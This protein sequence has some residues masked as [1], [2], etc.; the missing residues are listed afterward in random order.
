MDPLPPIPASADAA[1]LAVYETAP[2]RKLQCCVASFT[3]ILEPCPEDD[4]FILKLREWTD[5]TRGLLDSKKITDGDALEQGKRLQEILDNY[6]DGGLSILGVLEKYEK[7]CAPKQQVLSPTE[8]YLKKLQ[9]EEEMAEKA[10]LE[11]AGKITLSAAQIKD[12]LEKTK[13]SIEVRREAFKAGSLQQRQ[14]LEDHQEELLQI[15]AQITNDIRVLAQE[16]KKIAN[17]I[18]RTEEKTQELKERA[19][20]LNTNLEIIQKQADEARKNLTKKNN[21]FKEFCK[22]VLPVALAVLSVYSLG[23][24]G[25]MTVGKDSVGLFITV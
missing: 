24:A 17:S 22:V 5:Q 14:N 15:V 20:N 13:E 11:E 18:P 9:E 21:P 10:Y 8:A 4:P 6:Q 2:R 23:A 1:S 25:Y 7:A 16:N 19:E 3:L 12:N